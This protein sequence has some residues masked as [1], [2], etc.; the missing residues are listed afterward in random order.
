MSSCEDSERSVIAE[1]F[2]FPRKVG[3]FIMFSVLTPTK[4]V[5]QQIQPQS[6]DEM[7]AGFRKAAYT[8]VGQ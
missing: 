2:I 6:R 1:Y 4:A 8:A 7:N 5:G 3:G